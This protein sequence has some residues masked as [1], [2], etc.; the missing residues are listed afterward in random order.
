MK[1][2]PKFTTNNHLFSFLYSASQ[3]SM[4]IQLIE[5]IQPFYLQKV[6]VF[7]MIQRTNLWL[8]AVTMA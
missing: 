2:E 7:D 1:E 3:T 8:W 5:C 4:D 6:S